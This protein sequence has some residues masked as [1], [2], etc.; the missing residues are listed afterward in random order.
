[1]AVLS[2]KR[3]FGFKKKSLLIIL[4]SNK[5]KKE[6]K[7]ENSFPTTAI[8]MENNG[9]SLIR[10]PA[11]SLPHNSSNPNCFLLKSW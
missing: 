7:L 4:Y 9:C 8:S 6:R 3:G 5:K 11:S 2:R 1:M 10:W